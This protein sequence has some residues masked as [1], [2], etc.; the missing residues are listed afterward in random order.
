MA[1]LIVQIGPWA[2]VVGS[3]S[4]QNRLGRCFVASAEY[5]TKH[6]NA[7]PLALDLTLGLILRIGG[8]RDLLVLDLPTASSLAEFDKGV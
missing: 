1:A 4:P 7:Y 2:N 8:N 6:I 5:P 3:E